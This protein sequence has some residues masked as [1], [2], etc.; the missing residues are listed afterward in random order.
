MP[1]RAESERTATSEE[2]KARI[3]KWSRKYDNGGWVSVRWRIRRIVPS[4]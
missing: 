4:P 2:P 1:K 3:Q